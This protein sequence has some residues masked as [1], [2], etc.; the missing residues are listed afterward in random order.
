MEML[1]I[2]DQTKNAVQIMRNL[3]LCLPRDMFSNLKIF[4][5]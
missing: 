4:Q 3:G 1:K 2:C 5:F